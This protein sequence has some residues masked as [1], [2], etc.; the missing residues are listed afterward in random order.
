M[1]DPWE[2]LP[3]IEWDNEGNGRQRSKGGVYRYK[4]DDRGREFF[5]DFVPN[6]PEPEER[7]E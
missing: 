2:D 7:E 3:D 5:V 1:N 6:V 4:R